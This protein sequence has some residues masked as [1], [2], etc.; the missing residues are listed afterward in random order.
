[1]GECL[2]LVGLSPRA[3]HF[4]AQLSGGEQQR[5]AIARAL[6]KNPELLLC[7]EPTGALDY[8]TGKAVLSMLWDVNKRLRKTVLIITHNQAIARMADRLIRIRSGRIV[9]DARQSSPV[10]PEEVT[11]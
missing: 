3:E 6:A 4:P 1:V 8:E 10:R 9:E 7:D 11:W 2:H 5:V